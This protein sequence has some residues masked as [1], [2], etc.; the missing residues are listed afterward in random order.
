MNVY[1]KPA[2]IMDGR[3]QA[4]NETPEFF[5]G[6]ADNC[7]LSDLKLPYIHDSLFVFAD[8][9]SLDI[10]RRDCIQI[11][12]LVFPFRILLLYPFHISEIIIGGV[13]DH[14][15]RFLLLMVLP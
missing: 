6:P 9:C 12:Y 11:E 3:I 7:D 1:H 8:D 14:F 5:P 15:L 13:S 4:L 10:E 2:V